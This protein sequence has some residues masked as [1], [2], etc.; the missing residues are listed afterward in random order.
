MVI[1]GTESAPTS[2]KS[3]AVIIHDLLDIQP[4]ARSFEIKHACYGGTAA[5]QQA[6]DYVA[7]HPDRKF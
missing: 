6:H 7:L 5:L 2:P 4:F 3:A 1:V